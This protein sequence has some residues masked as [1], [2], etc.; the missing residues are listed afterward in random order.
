MCNGRLT[1]S[2]NPG[3]REPTVDDKSRVWAIAALVVGIFALLGAVCFSI[4]GAVLAVMGVVLSIVSLSKGRSGLAI[5][6]LAMNILALIAAAVSMFAGAYLMMS[7]EHP[8][9]R[10]PGAP[11]VDAAA[12]VADAGFEPPPL[13]PW[14]LDAGIDSGTPP[15]RPKTAGPTRSRR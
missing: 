9:F 6:A 14:P 2:R 7:G 13:A 3:D 12:M 11:V 4:C 8:L 5:A 15:P 1:A 10:P